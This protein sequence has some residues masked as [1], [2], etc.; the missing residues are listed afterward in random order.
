MKKIEENLQE[1][2]ADL[3]QRI[4]VTFRKFKVEKKETVYEDKKYPLYR[5]DIDTDEASVLIGHH[6]ETMYALQHL[7]KL[8]IWKKFNENIFVVV[9]VDSYRQRQEE[10]VK[11]IALSKA[12]LAR[13]TKEDQIL[14]PMSPYFRRVVHLYLAEKQFSDIVTESIGEGDNRQVI[15]RL[16][17]P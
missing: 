13:K 8:V 14:P 10:S 12:E 16:K 1:T 3:L 15:I 9:D 5:I 6:G 7:L 11:K 17:Q 4:G 2:L